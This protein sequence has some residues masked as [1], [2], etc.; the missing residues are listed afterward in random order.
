VAMTSLMLPELILSQ[1]SVQARVS[2]I[3]S[4][5]RIS[6]GVLIVFEFMAAAIRRATKSFAA[7]IATN[8]WSDRSHSIGNRRQ[9]HGPALQTPEDNWCGGRGIVEDAMGGWDILRFYIREHA[10]LNIKVLGF[11]GE[12]DVENISEVNVIHWLVVM[13]GTSVCIYTSLG[14]RFQACRC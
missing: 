8:T 11:R 9:W 13:L 4:R 10:G 14:G 3:L 6:R 7:N 12:V 5:T 1:H 2:A